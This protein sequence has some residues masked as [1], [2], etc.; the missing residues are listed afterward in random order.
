M[1]VRLPK[2][3]TAHIDR[4]AKGEKLTRSAAIRRLVELGLASARPIGRTSRAAAA[5][6]ADMAA[7][8]IDHIAPSSTPSEEQAS[9]KRRLLKGPREFRDIRKDHPKAKS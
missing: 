8:A 7:D 5:K 9:R 6:A 3:L 2:D 4:W 1:A